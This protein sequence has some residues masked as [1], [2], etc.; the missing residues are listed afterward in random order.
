MKILIVS[1]L[2]FPWRLGGAEVVA[3]STASALF[4]FGHH[5]HV[6]TLSPDQDTTQDWSNGYQI[7][8]IPLIN[9]YSIQ[10]MDRAS[11]FQ[12]VQW[13]I[14]DRWNDAMRIVFASELKTIRPDVVLLH[15]IAGFSIS[16]YRELAQA[17]IPFV[18]VLHDHYFGC[19][20]STMYRNSKICTFQ[21]AR[22]S[23]MRR[24]HLTTTRLANGVIGVSSYILSQMKSIGYFLDVPSHIIRNI[25]SQPN[26]VKTPSSHHQNTVDCGC[27]IGFLGVLNES[28]GILDLLFSFQQVARS[29]DRLLLAGNISMSS[30]MFYSLVNSDPRIS[31][32]GI[33]DRD[34]FFASIDILVVPSRV[35]EAFGLVAQEARF[36]GVPTVVANRGAL[37]E[38]SADTLSAYLY[39][40]DESD[41]LSIVLKALFA[42]RNS[43]RRGAEISNFDYMKLKTDW[44]KSYEAVLQD[45][46]Q[47]I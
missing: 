22:C 34:V 16:I 7:R 8:R 43:W 10:D 5:V 18:Q 9:V 44:G 26:Q 33:V 37:P 40:P 39:D 12:R 23:L 14:K 3:E 21:C 45:S 29:S 24:R 38:I 42:N 20:Y 32:M 4:E 11:T 28:K 31:Y 17:A 36:R 2:F 41:G 27:I 6:L 13:H 25:S 35:R 47:R 15:N 30:D 19:L 46:V 1:S